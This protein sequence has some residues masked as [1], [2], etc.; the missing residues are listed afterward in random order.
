MTFYGTKQ[1]ICLDK[2]IG[3]HELYAPYHMKHN[4]KYRI[5]FPKSEENLFA[6]TGQTRGDYKL[7][8]VK[9]EYETIDNADI[10]RNISN[11]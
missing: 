4:F 11:I 1:K 7:E 10:A 2:I 3:N 5:K 6:Q 9:L 8:N